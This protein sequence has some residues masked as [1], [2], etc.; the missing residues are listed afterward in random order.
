MIIIPPKDFIMKTVITDV[1]D[2]YK[3]EGIDVDECIAEEIEALWGV[4]VRTTGCCCGHG[5]T[6]GSIGV[7]KVD[8]PTMIKLGY[9]NLHGRDRVF[10]PKS[11]CKCE[12]GKKKWYRT[13]NGYLYNM[14]PDNA[15]ETLWGVQSES[16]DIEGILVAGDIVELIK[17]EEKLII[18]LKDRAAVEEAITMIKYMN[19]SIKAVLTKEKYN[20]AKEKLN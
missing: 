17:G 20:A 14:L 8:I 1:N 2:V 6:T 5:K 3:N 11:K 18:A 19:Y 4:G 16:D 7:E 12:E 9:K 10:I 13:I 15:K